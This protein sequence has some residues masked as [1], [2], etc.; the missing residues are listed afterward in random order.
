[1]NIIDAA[2]AMMEGKRVRHPQLLGSIEVAADEDCFEP[3]YYHDGSPFL[4]AL[5]EL[6][7]DDWEVIE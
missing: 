7:R 4:M 6:I 5:H 3:V 2:R 1:M